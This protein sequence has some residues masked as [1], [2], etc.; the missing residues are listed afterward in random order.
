MF[1]KISIGT[2][3][4]A[5]LIFNIY[6]ICNQTTWQELYTEGILFGDIFEYSTYG[7]LL[8]D[9]NFDGTPEIIVESIDF[10]GNIYDI[11]QGNVKKNG[12]I[13]ISDFALYKEKTTGRLKY[14]SKYRKNY[15]TGYSDCVDEL[16]YTG[17][18]VS[19][20]NEYTYNKDVSKESTYYEFKGRLVDPI[21]YSKLCNK[22]WD[23][24]EKVDV[25]MP[26]LP[27]EKIS[28]DNVSN[29][30]NSWRAFNDSSIFE[31]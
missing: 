29:W 19:I 24:L 26:Y 6:S 1:K 13:D 27:I 16:V 18:A 20:T 23:N 7:F 14:I 25:A 15:R 22:L 4:I 5:I 30:I 21:E 8:A 11:S 3:C 12:Y 2:V 17:A 10:S 28:R 9:L 31:Y